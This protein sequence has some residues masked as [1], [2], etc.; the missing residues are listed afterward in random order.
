[1]TAYIT[2]LLL[3]G[4]VFIYWQWLSLRQKMIQNLLTQAK[5][6]ADNCKASIAFQVT[7]DAN[8]TLQTLKAEKS[9]IFGRV[10]TADGNIFAS[11][12]RNGIETKLNLPVPRKAD[13]IFD[14][15]FLTVFEPVI[16]ESEYIGTA[17]LRSDLV[18][19][20]TTL[21]N[22]IS[23]MVMVLLLVSLPAYFISSGL[24]RIISS[25]ILNLANVAKFVSEKKEYSVRAQ[26][27][28]KDEVG[29]L[30]DAF[31]EM[32]E[33]I[34]ERDLAMINTNEQLEKKVEERTAELKEEIAVRKKAEYKLAQTVKKLTVSTKELQEFT[35]VSAHDLKTPLRGIGTLSDWISN[36]YAGKADEEGQRHARMLA[37]RANRMSKLLDAVIQYTGLTLLDRKEERLDLNILLQEI[38]NKINPPENIEITIESELPFLT[39]VHDFIQLVF[40]NL[41]NNAIKF[42]DKPKGKIMIGCIESDNEWQFSITDNGPGI[43]ERYHEK[44]FQIFQILSLRDETE[45]IGIGLSIVKKIVELYDGHI[46]IVSTPGEGST[47]FFTFPKKKGVE[48]VTTGY[49]TG[50]TS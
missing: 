45:N 4:V 38:I 20:N 14:N 32:L 16:L 37:Q 50:I 33:Q 15:K 24:Q 7:E 12:Y 18:N 34:Q 42:I 26:K 5:M 9:I 21:K 30:I 40:E 3:A 11:Y 36:D 28:S 46:W 31:N 48:Y 8:E 49:K 27:N 35:R 10:Y 41:L 22:N 25:P 19:L 44:I 29:L 6:I 17:C 47:F 39:G 23:I 43:E 1:M 2:A 13:Y